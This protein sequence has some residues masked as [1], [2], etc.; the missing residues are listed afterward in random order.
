MDKTPLT[1][2]DIYHLMNIHR[3]LSCFQ[4][5]LE[6]IISPQQT[7]SLKQSMEK[8]ENKK[9]GGTKFK[10]RAMFHLSWSRLCSLPF[11]DVSDHTASKDNPQNL[12]K[13]KQKSQ[14]A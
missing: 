12:K 14:E 8:L 4:K 1:Q 13:N 11:A 5:E 3:V 9:G 2:E 6:T 7:K 10:G